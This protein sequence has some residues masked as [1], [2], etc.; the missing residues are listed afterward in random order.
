MCAAGPQ[1][2]FTKWAVKPI[3]HR[4]L[5][6]GRL[7]WFLF[8]LCHAEPSRWPLFKTVWLTGGTETCF[9]INSVFSCFSFYTGLLWTWLTH[10]KVLIDSYSLVERWV[11]GK[12]C[13]FMRIPSFPLYR[14]LFPS[15]STVW[16]VFAKS[17]SRHG[18]KCRP[19]FWHCNN[20]TFDKEKLRVQNLCLPPSLF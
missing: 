19:P 2:W 7:W 11:E 3:L 13:L 8:V 1:W 10:K 15:F 20:I 14:G 9:S 16:F 17:S 18:Y 6:C 4:V 12:L 5:S